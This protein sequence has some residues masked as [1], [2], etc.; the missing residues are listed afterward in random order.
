MRSGP[1]SVCGKVARRR[2]SVCKTVYCSRQCQTEDWRDHI[3]LC[4]PL[5]ALHWVS[6]RGDQQPVTYPEAIISRE[7]PARSPDKDKLYRVFPL[8][9]FESCQQFSVKIVGEVR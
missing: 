5:P 3:S 2:C 7:L 1:C 9:N 8:D 4:Q 6:E